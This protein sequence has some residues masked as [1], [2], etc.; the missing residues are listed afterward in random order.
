MGI[1]SYV[2]EYLPRRSASQA[3]FPARARYSE[4]SLPLK[5]V[6]LHVVYHKMVPH[7]ATDK[8]MVMAR[9]ILSA[10]PHNSGC[11]PLQPMLQCPLSGNIE[12][13]LPESLEGEI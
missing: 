1:Q 5:A 10:E 2:K 4:R 9:P 7:L 11:H 8:M 6:L 12:L 3:I 13:Y